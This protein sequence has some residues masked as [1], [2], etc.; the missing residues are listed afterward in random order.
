MQ[1]K[2]MLLAAISAFLLCVFSPASLQ[3]IRVRSAAE[4]LRSFVEDF[5]SDPAAS[6]PITFGVRIRNEERGEWQ[7]VVSGKK[8]GVEAY[9]VELRQG[10]PSS[11]SAIYTLDLATVRKI[12]SGEINVLTA[13]GRARAS[14]PTPMDI[15]FM[16]GFQPDADF[17]ARFIPFTF[18][19]WTR[20][21][22][23]T[24]NFG[25]EHSREVHG[26]NMVVFYYQKGL[27]S[28]WAQIEK[29][30]HVNRDP[31]DQANPFPTMIIGIRGKAMAKIAGKEVILQA[32]QMAFI[33][34]GVSHE[35]WNPYDEPAEIIL[36]M[37]G[38]GA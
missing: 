3:S 38:A 34:A 22:P 4:I 12:D 24:V 36:L 6:E 37:F 17:F 11:P 1:K 28:A 7:V 31:K 29:G 16:A 35:A 10:L 32:G 23:E 5:Q 18:H 2:K 8:E 9:Q 21:F 33:P 26:A 13:M 25:K 20:G 15:E 27:R 30:Q 14:D 19:F